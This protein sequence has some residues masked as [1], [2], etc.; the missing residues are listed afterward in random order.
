M[1]ELQEFDLTPE[2]WREYDF[3]GRVYRIDNP[4]TLF[5]RQGG[6]TH[7]IVDSAGIVHCLPVPGVNGCVLRWQNR[8]QDIPVNF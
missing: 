6:T 3:V 7:R 5:F 8:D 1:S 2:L 4:K